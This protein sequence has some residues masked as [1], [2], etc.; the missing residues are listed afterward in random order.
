V[1][2]NYIGNMSS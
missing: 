1:T 2:K